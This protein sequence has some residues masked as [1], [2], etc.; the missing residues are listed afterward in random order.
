L[1][2]IIHEVISS[3]L[4]HQ[5]CTYLYELSVAFSEFYEVCYCISKDENN[6]TKVNI[7]RILLCEATAKTLDLGLKLLGIQSVNKM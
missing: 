4:P 5:L 3:L 1:P 2:E 6:E 7:D